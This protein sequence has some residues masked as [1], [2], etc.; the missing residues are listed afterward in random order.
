MALE[1]TWRWFGPKDPISLKEIKQ[2]G[3]T[4]IVTA[5]H[6]IPIGEVWPVDEIMK[7]KRI[8]EAEGLTWS[9][10]ESIPVHE[11]IKKREGNYR[12][13]LENYKASIRNLGQCGIDTVCYNFMPVLDWSRTDLEV[14]FKDGSITTKFE[15]KVFAAFDLFILKRPGAEKNYHED[16]IQ[17]AEQYFATLD[18]NQRQ[19]LIQTILL[20]FP[21][22]WESYTLEK[23]LSALRD[24]EGIGDTELRENL[25][26]FLRE[27][28][29]V[30]EEAGV[31]MAIHPDDPPWP[32]LG[33]P[34]VVSH[35]PDIERILKVND[36]P[37]N[38]LTLCTGSLGAS[39]KN[40]LVDMA[41]SFAPRIN[42]VHLR[43]VTRNQD[44]D[45]IEDNHLDGDV[46]M[47]GV[48]KALIIEQK[49]RVEEGRKDTRMPFRPD[50]GHLMLP[51]QHRQGIYPG[52]SLFGRMRG[53]AELRGL[54]LGIR[55]SLGI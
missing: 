9:V 54:E 7:R 51:D 26:I 23:L 53:L 20:G 55:R 34:R 31:L 5:L 22:S 27:I 12:Q 35:K 16:Q 36:S 28:I 44:G 52:Y 47:Y 6:H 18:E 39:A 50:H 8:I 19:K 13:Y 2:T 45:F 17:Q 24:Y 37:S 49:R 46:D 29:P 32:L 15:A 40:D 42:F 33:L 11:D 30:A 25:Y 1:Q 10:A 41:E 48:M 21:G 14:V 38:G 3:A 43:N 4:G